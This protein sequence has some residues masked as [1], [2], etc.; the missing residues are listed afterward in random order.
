MLDWYQKK[1]KCKDHNDF[2]NKYERKSWKIW[3]QK[4]GCPSNADLSFAGQTAKKI[5]FKYKCFARPGTGI[6]YSYAC[7]LDNMQQI[8]KNDIIF[9]EL[10][11]TYRYLSMLDNVVQL[12]ALKNDVLKYFPA[13]R[14]MNDMYSL[15]FKDIV[16]RNINNI[17]FINVYKNNAN[18][19]NEE[20]PD[21]FWHNS[22]TLGNM[23]DDLGMV[24]MPTS[25]YHQ[26]AH[27]KFSDYLIKEIIK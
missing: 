15:M 6:D 17:Y 20:L 26:D 9:F 10:P 5:N 22:V 3:Y 16:S 7:L 1:M 2:Y 18:Q 8:E 11:P 21:V 19:V 4:Y 27:D 12:S 13:E 23:S 24:R 14:T 25:H